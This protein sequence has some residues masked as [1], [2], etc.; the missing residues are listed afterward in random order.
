[1]PQP[2]CERNVEAAEHN[3]EPANCPD[4]RNCTGTGLGNQ[5]NAEGNRKRTNLRM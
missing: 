1:L 2:E 4:Q 3:R 5:D